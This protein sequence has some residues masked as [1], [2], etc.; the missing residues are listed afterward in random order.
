MGSCIFLP[1]KHS[2]CSKSNI[3]ILKKI[4]KSIAILLINK[5]HKYDIEKK[6]N[7]NILIAN[8]HE[9]NIISIIG[10]IK[11]AWG[12]YYEIMFYINQY[13]SFKY[14]EITFNKIINN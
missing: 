9:F 1:F 12:A 5:G 7:V 6:F 14:P 13:K 3:K 10:K 4:N 2:K 8:S 11:N